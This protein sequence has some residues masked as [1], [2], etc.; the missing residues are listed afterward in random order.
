MKSNNYSLPCAIKILSL[1][2]INTFITIINLIAVF[3][4]VYKNSRNIQFI[5]L[6][7][8]KLTTIFLVF[9]LCLIFFTSMSLTTS[10]ADNTKKKPPSRYSLLVKSNENLDLYREG[11]PKRNH[12]RR[13]LRAKQQNH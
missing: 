6:F 11:H 13:R 2:R 9:F 7:K 8:M 4:L 12:H 3:I 10:N 5:D 1:K